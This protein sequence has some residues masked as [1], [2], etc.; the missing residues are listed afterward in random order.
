MSTQPKKEI[1]D[2]DFPQG[3]SLIEAN[4]GTGKT[5]SIELIYLKALLELKLEVQ[6]ILLVTFTK[7]QVNLF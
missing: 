1:L 3:I 6:Q 4:A 7:Q 5:F 2:Y